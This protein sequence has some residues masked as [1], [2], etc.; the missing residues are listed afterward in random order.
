MNKK[1]TIVLLGVFFLG[2][3]LIII[4]QL[5][6]DLEKKAAS[7]AQKT[8]SFEV[9]K[10]VVSEPAKA[11]PTPKQ[12]ALAPTAPAAPAPAQPPAAPATQAAALPAPATAAPAG[13]AGPS[14]AAPAAPPTAAPAPAAP[15]SHASSAP[16]SAKAPEPAPAPAPAAVASEK[17]AAAAKAEA[18]PA[19]EPKDTAK[20]AAAETKTAA[21]ETKTASAPKPAAEPKTAAKF[22][23]MNGVKQINVTASGDGVVM[24]ITTQQPFEKFA[25]FAM[26]SPSRLIVDI[27]GQWRLFVG[28]AQVAQNTVVKDVRVG[29]HPGKLRVVAD[30][31]GGAPS[32]VKVVKTSATTLTVTFR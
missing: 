3:A 10:P 4:S 1:Y 24:T 28:G 11:A 17:Q 12:T 32:G 27:T 18:K 14:T 5:G 26:G 2:M 15:A 19:A 30:C 29:L 25:H 22:G 6:K 20:P 16:A 31:V 13:P 7:Q 9:K 21:A 23:G 8:E